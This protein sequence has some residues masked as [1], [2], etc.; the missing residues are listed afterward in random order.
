VVPIK[1]RDVSGFGINF[2]GLTA[3]NFTRCIEPEDVEVLLVVSD[4]DRY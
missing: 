3:G 1:D 2:A 4:G